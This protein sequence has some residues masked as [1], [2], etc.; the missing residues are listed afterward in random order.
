MLESVAE[1][2][3]KGAALA[4]QER[5]RLI[6]PFFWSLSKSDRLRRSMPHGTKKL[7]ADWI[8]M[9]AAR[10]SRST[11]KKSSPKRAGWLGENVPLPCCCPQGIA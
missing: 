4:P 3:A 8:P 10:H 9:I 5:S 11:A 7:S 6:D 1:L 2:A